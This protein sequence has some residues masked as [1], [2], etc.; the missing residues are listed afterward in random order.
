MKKNQLEA[1]KKL[2]AAL[3]SVKRAGLVLVGIDGNIVVTVADDALQDEMRDRSGCEAI[4]DRV[5][6]DHEGTDSAKHYGAY[7]DSGG[8]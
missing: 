2:E 3:L 5:N 1:I 6:T 4:L 7:L 8:A